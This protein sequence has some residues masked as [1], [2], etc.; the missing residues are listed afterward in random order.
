MRGLANAARATLLM[1]LALPVRAAVLDD[2]ED[3]AAW[4][5]EATEGVKAE[6]RAEPGVTGSALCLEFDFGRVS[7]YAM[8]RLELPIDFPQD[9]ELDVSVRGDAPRNALHVRFSD[10]SGENVWRSS[11]SIVP[12]L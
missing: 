8:M 4:R 1:A 12:K 11:R 9:F 7:G 5:I 6:L 3:L 10:A 2:F